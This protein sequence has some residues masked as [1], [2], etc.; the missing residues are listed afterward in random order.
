MSTIEYRRFKATTRVVSNTESRSAE[1]EEKAGVVHGHAIVFESDSVDMGFI[2][3]IAPTALDR[4]LRAAEH[5]GWNI[6]ML[7][8]HDGK[9][10]PLGSTRSGKLKLKTDERGLSFELDPARLTFA[11]LDAIRD[12]DMQMSFGFSVEKEDQ[13]IE[14]QADG[15]VVRTINDLTLYEIS[16]VQTP[17]YPETEVGVR[18]DPAWLIEARSVE[19]SPDV[20]QVESDEPAAQQA[21]VVDFIAIRRAKLLAATEAKLRVLAAR[22]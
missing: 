4:S 20:D 16:A 11:Q 10:P 17:A 14:R 8:E 6:V 12:G 22:K 19:A 3:R 2:E 15:T 9:Q 1:S 5:D 13:T 18:A 7:W 21:E